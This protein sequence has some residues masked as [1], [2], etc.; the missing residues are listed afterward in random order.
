MKKINL[1][2]LF[3]ALFTFSS[4]KNE[5]QEDLLNYVNVEIPQISQLEIDAM[6][7]YASVSGDNY[8]S[9]Q[10][11]YD[12]LVNDIIPKYK[13]FNEGLEAISA[14]LTSKEVKDLNEKYLKGSQLQF[15]GMTLIQTA[16]ENQDMKTM[17]EANEKLNDGRKLK[18]EFQDDI[19]KLS[20]ENNV[21]IKK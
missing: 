21:E 5:V 17:T 2:L 10:I 4:C 9:D 12:K 16:L 6:A 8:Q 20:K 11:M 3:I 13:K 15:S 7:D 18:R 19:K 1:L 14:K